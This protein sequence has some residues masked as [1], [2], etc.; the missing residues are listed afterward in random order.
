MRIAQVSDSLIS[1]SQI[2][3]KEEL[4]LD[5]IPEKPVPSEELLGLVGE[6][7]LHSLGLASWWPTGRMQYFMEQ[8]HLG[9]GSLIELKQL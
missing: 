1:S 7:T 2:D 8:I 9:R 3:G 4:I 5:W 6:P